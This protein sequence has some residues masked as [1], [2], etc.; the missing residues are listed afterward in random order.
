MTKANTSTPSG[1]PEFSPKF[2]IVRQN[3]MRNIAEIFEK[4]GFWPIETP[5]VERADNLVAKGGNPKEIYVLD[6]LLNKEVGN[7]KNALRFD[8][9]VPLA[10]FVARHQ[11]EINFPFRR[12]VIGPVFRGERAQKGRFRQFDQCDIDVIGS[13]NLPIFYDAEVAAIVIKVF[14]KL[15]PDNNFFVRINNRKILS[16]FF[17]SL[18]IADDQIM[19]VIK[20]VDDLEKMSRADILAQFE[21]QGIDQSVAEKV[22]DFTEISGTN[23]EILRKLKTV[24][25]DANFLSAVEELETVIQTLKNMEIPEKYFQIDLRIARGLD[26]YTGTVFETTLVGHEDL[27]SICSGGRYDDLASIFTGRKMPGV[28]ISIGL[29]RLLSQLFD[30]GIVKPEKSSP[31]EILIFSAEQDFDNSKI[32]KA[33]YATADVLQEKFNTQI[34]FESKKIVKKFEYAEKIGAI[35]CAIIGS[36][37]ADKGEVTIKDMNNGKQYTVKVGDALSVINKNIFKK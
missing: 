31:T 24:S 36:D 3:W 11:T 19:T 26:Y 28:G 27:G 15:L 25:D 29:T 2:E 32:A 20:I 12:Y 34:Y 18:G 17:S 35:F 16:E 4:N 5:L 37:E 23:E 6:R 9:T 1:F 21:S 33:I 13:E 22:L 8:Q 30:A 10:L 7:K 14:R